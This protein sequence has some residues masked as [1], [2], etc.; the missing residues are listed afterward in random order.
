[1][2]LRLNSKVTTSAST[3]IFI[4]SCRLRR[5]R[6]SSGRCGRWDARGGTAATSGAEDLPSIR[7]RPSKRTRP[8]FSDSL[9]PFSVV[10]V[11]NLGLLGQ[12]GLGREATHFIT[13]IINFAIHGDLSR[14]VNL[15]AM[16]RRPT[17][18]LSVLWTPPPLLPLPKRRNRLFPFPAARGRGA[19]CP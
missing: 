13:C 11:D 7:Q 19:S 8:V 4:L 16:P 12:L 5:R 15:L 3:L 9:P 17:K 14:A 10:L 18:E 1:M 6:A 2:C